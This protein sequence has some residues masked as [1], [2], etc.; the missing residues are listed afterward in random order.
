VRLFNTLTGLA[1][2]QSYNRILV[3]PDAMRDTFLELIDDEIRN[4]RAGRH[5][6]II[7]KMNQLEDRRINEKL[8][9]ASRAGVKID[10]IIRGFC[11]LRPG[12]RGL[13]DTIRVRSVVGRFL[14]HARV[15]YFSRGSDDP[16]DG[17]YYIS[18]ADWMYRN[19]SNRV[20]SACPVEDLSARAR[21]WH[22]FDIHLRDQADAWDLG[23]DGLYTRATPP[24][25]APKDA[26][27]RMGTFET[28]MRAQEEMT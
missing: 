18:S 14:E 7:A 17:H 24:P 15:F 13:S 21:L 25:E 23:P 11:C 20:E 12:V 26:P 16:L 3:A 5:A 2:G 22:M 9:E 1:S 10:L 8:Y 19:L 27:E 4:A 28:L 6:H